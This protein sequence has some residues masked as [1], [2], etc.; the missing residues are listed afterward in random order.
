MTGWRQEFDSLL[1][2]SGEEHR[3]LAGSL[4]GS[5]LAG[6]LG[7]WRA[8]AFGCACCMYLF[9]HA[10]IS[11]RLQPNCQEGSLPGHMPAETRACRCEVRADPVLGLVLPCQKR[12]VLKCCMCVT[13][14]TARPAYIRKLC[15]ALLAVR[16][17]LIA[18]VAQ[19]CVCSECV[20]RYSAE[21]V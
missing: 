8:G 20:C 4:A 5:W 13:V 1:S 16:Q 3:V 17:L 10:F 18:L 21:M 11:A 6:W 12:C 19:R 2:G 9:A 7:S 14:G 15:S